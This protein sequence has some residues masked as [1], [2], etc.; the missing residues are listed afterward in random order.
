MRSWISWPLAGA[1]VIASSL[2]RPDWAWSIDRKD[3]LEQMKKSRPQDLVVLIEEPDAGGNRI[4]GMY[5]LKKEAGDPTLRR[6]SI[7]E[8][9]PA[10]IN[11]FQ[12]TV[13]CSPSDPVRVKRTETA[14][15]VRTINPGGPIIEGNREDHLVWWAACFPELAGT[16]PSTLKE[17]ALSLG[18]STLVPERREKLPVV[19]R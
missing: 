13:Y 12:E 11:I 4:I 1:L 8:E 17:K 18:Y 5:G 16:D 15:F 2:L 9:S 10:D 6:F 14:V 7:W 3:V 19:P